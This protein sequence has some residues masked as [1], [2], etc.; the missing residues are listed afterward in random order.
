MF[1][2]IEAK[3]RKI[4]QQ[5]VKRRRRNRRAKWNNY[6]VSRKRT[7]SLWIQNDDRTIENYCKY[8]LKGHWI[9]TE[10]ELAL[11]FR[12]RTHCRKIQYLHFNTYSHALRSIVN[13]ICTRFLSCEVLNNT[14]GEQFVSGILCLQPDDGEYFLYYKFDLGK[15]AD[16][17]VRIIMSMI[18]LYNEY[19]TSV[20]YYLPEL[21]SVSFV[22]Q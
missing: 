1:V 18:D 10:D 11:I 3:F 19:C 6:T 12:V 13:H 22:F 5:I 20:F 16:V 15:K 17:N 2:E 4:D 21:K 7:N 14:Y 9:R 8:G